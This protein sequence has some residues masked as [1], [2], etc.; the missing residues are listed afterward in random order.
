MHDERMT[1]VYGDELASYHFSDEHPL[2]PSR[3]QLTMA[4]L[5]L[6][7]WLDD[8]RITMLKPRPATTSELMTVHSYPYIQA[9]IHAQSIARGERPP[10]DLTLYGLGLEDN[11]LFPDIADAPTLYTG[12]S[13]Q[14][15]HALLDGSALHAY[16]PAGGMHHAMKTHAEGFCVYND[17]S[18]AIA[19]AVA[20][21]HR[22]AYIDLDA[23]HG[24]GVQ[25]SFY[26][27][28]R[29]LTIS[30]HES[31]RFLFP[32]TGEACETGTGEG[33]GTCVNVPLPPMAGN[34]E[35]LAAVDRIVIPAV[36]AFAP[37]IVVTQ[38]GCD[39]HH[40]DPLTDLCATLD[41]YPQLAER[42]HKLVHEVCGG[43]WLIVGGGGYDPADVTPR[44]WTA[45]MGTVLG[46]DVENVPLPDE[47]LQLSREQGG[48]PPQH[49]LDD[50]GTEFTP[51][52]EEDF[53]AL[54]AEVEE[55]ALTQLWLRHGGR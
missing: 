23:H 55:T 47:W 51:V 24:D 12:A 44:A 37:S 45:F 49:L 35:I 9:V 25:D 11:P 48:D 10:V 27:D 8:A 16:S 15:M 14:A 50:A 13:I 5:R 36:E 52:I 6:L 19:A 33:F 4:L 18:A 41:L 29:V 28:P 32:G 30:V 40:S 26:H 31:G 34:T 39:M 22:V 38:T 17:I 42:H 54:L 21:G 20:A 1:I 2:Q 46:H 43:R 3:H 53:P 7:G